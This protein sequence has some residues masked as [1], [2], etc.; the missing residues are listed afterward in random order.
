MVEECPGEGWR[1]WRVWQGSGTLS[2][3]AALQRRVLSGAGTALDSGAV[4]HWLSSGVRDRS[5]RASPGERACQ[6]AA[7]A[8]KGVWQENRALPRAGQGN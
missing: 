8:G 1:A 6:C 4:S 3:E 7:G 5:C 2:V